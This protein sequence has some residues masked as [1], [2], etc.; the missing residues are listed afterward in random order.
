MPRVR[1]A[2]QYKFKRMAELNRM[3]DG[4]DAGA[5]QVKRSLNDSWQNS[6]P[7]SESSLKEYWNPNGSKN[8]AR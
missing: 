8:I 1:Y 7:C 2:A 3:I 6:K 5:A 4:G